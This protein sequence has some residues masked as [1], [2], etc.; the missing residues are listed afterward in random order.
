MRPV[1]KPTR[2]LLLRKMA[3]G[4]VCLAAMA[5][6][7]FARASPRFEGRPELR[8]AMDLIRATIPHRRS[9]ARLGATYL[10]SAP[11]EH[12]LD[13]LLDILKTRDSGI[14]DLINAGR[15]E[16]VSST[17]HRRIAADFERGDVVE[18]DGWVL[19][20]TEVRLAAL[21]HVVRGA[22]PSA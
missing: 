20:L 16:V 22:F 5:N 13:R 9:A 17:F 3:V 4:C 15:S 2:R 18:V 14:E 19:S 8:F 6:P 1:E 11:D 7:G 21:A 10:L 12:D